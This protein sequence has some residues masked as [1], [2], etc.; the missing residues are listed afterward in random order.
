MKRSGLKRPYSSFLSRFAAILT[1]TFFMASF[2]YA[3]ENSDA[4]ESE[5]A[6]MMGQHESALDSAD[7]LRDFY[8]NILN[9]DFPFVSRAYNRSRDRVDVADGFQTHLADLVAGMSGL[10]ACEEEN[11]LNY[12]SLPVSIEQLDADVQAL[13]EALRKSDND[14]D[15]HDIRDRADDLIENL[16]INIE[17]MGS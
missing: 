7:F 2:G 12:T 14:Y 3:Q 17:S 1:I 4:C 10:N 5:A 9:N 16:S 13:D 8:Q 6:E 11:G 15:A